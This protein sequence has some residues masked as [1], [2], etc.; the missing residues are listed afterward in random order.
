MSERAVHAEMAKAE[1]RRGGECIFRYTC[2]D[3]HDRYRKEL[4]HHSN[5]HR[6]YPFHTDLYGI[7]YIDVDT[8]EVYNYIPI[9]RYHTYDA[10]CGESFIIISVHYNPKTDLVAYEGCIWAGPSDV[11]VGDLSDPL[12]FD[13]HLFSIH[14]IIDPDYEECSDIDFVCWTDE[15][16]EVMV[17]EKRTQSISFEEIRRGIEKVRENSIN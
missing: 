1:L 4:I 5:G 10:V 11:M 14:D 2:I 3:L 12:N 13:P 6:Y 7:S 9:G 8:L 16:I 15:G 17:D